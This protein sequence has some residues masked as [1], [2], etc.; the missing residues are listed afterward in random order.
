MN[1]RNDTILYLYNRLSFLFFPF[2]SLSVSL[3][4]TKA[5]CHVHRILAVYVIILTLDVFITGPGSVYDY[6]KERLF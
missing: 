4:V 5:D 6:M 1:N 3:R 2:S